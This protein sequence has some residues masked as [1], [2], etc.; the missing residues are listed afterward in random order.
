MA[1]GR[2][3]DAR[4]RLFDQRVDTQAASGSWR[5]WFDDRA[6]VRFGGRLWRDVVG[7]TKFG[8]LHRVDVL[9]GARPPASFLLS[10]AV[11]LLRR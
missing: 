2:E 3:R 9:M 11:E 8:G 6:A 7:G 1:G 4:A 5:L 10:S